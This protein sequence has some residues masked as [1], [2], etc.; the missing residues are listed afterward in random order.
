M[1]FLDHL[2]ISMLSKQVNQSWIS[3]DKFCFVFISTY[4]SMQ[5]APSLPTVLLK[6]ASHITLAHN[7]NTID[8]QLAKR[9]TIDSATL[10]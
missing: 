6:Y 10:N 5:P 7:G 4:Q 3:Q 9:I 2:R 1:T 8:F